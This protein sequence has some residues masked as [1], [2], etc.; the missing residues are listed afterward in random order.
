MVPIGRSA[1]HTTNNSQEE[2][3]E[4]VE[5]EEHIVVLDILS[6]DW[7]PYAD[8]GNGLNEDK[9]TWN[10]DSWQSD[11]KTEGLKFLSSPI[12]KNT[13]H[14]L[15]IL[16]A[17]WEGYLIRARTTTP[18]TQNSTRMNPS[19][20]MIKVMK[21]W[22]PWKH[23]RSAILAARRMSMETM[24]AEVVADG[25]TPLTS[26]EVVSKV[27][28]QNSSNTT[29]L[30]NSSIGTPTSKSP[31]VGEAALCEELAAE[32]QGSA[33]LQQEVEELKKTEAAEVAMVRT[34]R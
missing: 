16:I 24:L 17:S 33:V 11:S 13:K 18:N 19:T 25:Q 34:Q 3:Q 2:I 4:G 21:Q 23:S 7:A 22:M 31:S 27:L 1:S 30:K 28:S 10:T 12:G 14:N 6:R 9:T 5:K 20:K 29:F 32:K 8:D 26:A 15:N